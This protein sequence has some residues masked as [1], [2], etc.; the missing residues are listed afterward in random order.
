MNNINRA[1]THSGKVKCCNYY[2]EHGPLT[3][4]ICPANVP[5][6]FLFC[7]PGAFI[8]AIFLIIK[9]IQNRLCSVCAIKTHLAHFVT[10]LLPESLG[11]QGK[12]G[13]SGRSW[14][15]VDVRVRLCTRVDN[16]RSRRRSWTRAGP[17]IP[18]VRIKSEP[19][20]TEQ[21]QTLHV[22]TFIM[23]IT[24]KEATKSLVGRL[25]PVVYKIFKV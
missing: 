17:T 25:F 3:R 11:L 15:F 4:P 12:F 5:G 7:I 13:G 22:A 23:S 9:L 16:R 24:R 20:P 6:V 8:F 10:S 2:Q 18:A 19:V 14:T 21:S 1:S